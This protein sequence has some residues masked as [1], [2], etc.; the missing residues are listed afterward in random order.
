MK[1]SPLLLCS[2]LA[3]F[4]FLACSLDSGGVVQTSSDGRDGSGG[5]DPSSSGGGAA[6]PP[7]GG[8]PTGTGGTAPSVALTGGSTVLVVTDTGG[9]AAPGDQTLTEEETCTGLALEPDSIQVEEE[10]TTTLETQ[11][12][13]P[14]A[15]YVVLDNSRSMQ[16]TGTTGTTGTKWDEAVTALT[17][18]V[19]DPASGG[20]DV[21]IQYFHPVGAAEEPDECDGVA[22]ATPAVAMGRLPEQAPAIVESLQSTELAQSTPTVGALTGGTSYCASFQASHPDEKCVVVLVTDGQP[23]ACG[24]SAICDVPREGE[25]G[26]PGWAFGT[27]CVD[28]DAAGLLTP[29]AAGGL[30][31]GVVTF[32]IGMAGVTAEGFQLLDQVAVAGGSDCTPELPGAEACDVTTSGAEGFLA[33]LNAIRDSVTVVETII[34]TITT[35]QIV[36]L[37]CEWAV[38]EPPAGETLDPKLVNV[39]VIDVATSPMIYVP[40]AA[41]CALA[42]GPAWYYDD[43]IAPTKI[44]VCPATCDTLTAQT[45]ARVEVL[46]GCEREELLR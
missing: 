33:A 20:I 22:H 29:I 16:E 42:S 46:F 30:T 23:N 28:P 7:E 9:T 32:T 4:A 38:P 5:A 40:S 19:E 10:L 37:P 13:A 3:L 15:L 18:F 24:L 1:R 17:R 27:T 6:I 12:P 31:S 25:G 35:T 36:T 44:L 8:A 21:A 39:N 41:D 14:V 2:P 11:V 45:T 26:A 43:P 34:E